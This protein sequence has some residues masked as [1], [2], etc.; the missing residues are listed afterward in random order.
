MLVSRYF[1]IAITP[2]ELHIGNAFSQLQMSEE[3]PSESDRTRFIESYS[4]KE[5][6]CSSVQAF[7]RSFSLFSEVDFLVR[8][9]HIDMDI[10][11]DAPHAHFIL[12]WLCLTLVLSFHP[13]T[14]S[15]S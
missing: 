13:S 6:I 14:P 9:M 4:E 3:E 12:P 10:P 11:V 8:V 7:S 15:S 1:L 2:R 5:Q